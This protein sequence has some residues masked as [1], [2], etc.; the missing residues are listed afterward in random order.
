MGKKA[1]FI[2]QDIFVISP[3]RAADIESNFAAS[4]HVP[5]Q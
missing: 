4:E 2:K 1:P 5:G 3:R